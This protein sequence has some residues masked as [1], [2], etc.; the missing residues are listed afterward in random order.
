MKRIG[1]LLQKALFGAP[2]GDNCAMRDNLTDPLEKIIHCDVLLLDKPIYFGN[3]TR[4]LFTFPG[5]LT[6][7]FIYSM[8]I[9]SDKMEQFGYFH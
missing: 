4:D 6:S 5:K 2:S 9:D 3:I 7:E 1:T 8:N